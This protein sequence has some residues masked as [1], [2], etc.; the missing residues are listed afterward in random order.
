MFGQVRSLIDTIHDSK[1]DSGS[2]SSNERD[3]EKSTRADKY[4]GSL[5]QQLGTFLDILGIH[6]EARITRMNFVG[7]CEKF[8][9]L[10]S[11]VQALQKSLKSA[12]YGDQFW[13]P[14]I[15]FRLKS[16]PNAAAIHYDLLKATK[17]VKSDDF[18]YSSAETPRQHSAGAA[19]AAASNSATAAAQRSQQS[20]TTTTTATAA[21]AGS[22]V[23]D[24]ERGSQ[25][26][27]KVSIPG[28]ASSSLSAPSPTAS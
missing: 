12:M 3:K 15:L 19:K 7:I 24:D 13:S 14:I 28:A 21:A 17:A 4:N 20:A 10:V 2:G 9:M 26:Q 25:R 5:K 23:A 18:T 16:G 27:D 11:P 22:D 6:D 1:L 8:P